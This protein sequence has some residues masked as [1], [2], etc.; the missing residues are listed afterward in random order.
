[1]PATKELVRSLKVHEAIFK[2]MVESKG[3]STDS[4]SRP[5]KQPIAQSVERLIEET[6]MIHV[7]ASRVVV[8][9]YLA[10][11]AQADLKSVQAALATPQPEAAPQAA[12][13]SRNNTEDCGRAEDFPSLSR[14]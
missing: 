1:V 8:G 13:A 5:P 12:V 3:G 9:E 2:R 11:C 14:P 10:P 6:G 4:L 7:K